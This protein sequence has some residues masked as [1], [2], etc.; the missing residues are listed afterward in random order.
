[1]RYRNFFKLKFLS[2]IIIY[3]KKVQK[4]LMCNEN[5]ELWRSVGTLI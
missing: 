2:K 3:S 1:M 5:K 4:E